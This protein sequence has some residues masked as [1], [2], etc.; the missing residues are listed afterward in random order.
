FDARVRSAAERIRAEQK[1]SER[2]PSE[3]LYRRVKVRRGVAKHRGKSC[4]MR[5]NRVED[6]DGVREDE[7]QEDW[8]EDVHRLLDPA[9]VENDHDRDQPE[10]GREFVRSHV[11]WEK[12]PDLITR[13]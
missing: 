10:F 1:Q 11:Q 12:R 4:E 13:G 2:P 7:E 8:R 9:Q 6:C 5:N 3:R